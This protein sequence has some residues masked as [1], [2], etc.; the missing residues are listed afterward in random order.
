MTFENAFLL[1]AATLFLFAVADA[2][3]FARQPRDERKPRRELF[4]EIAAIA[5][6]LNFFAFIL[7]DVLL[8]GDA[9]NGK[10]DS[11]RYYLGNHGA[12]TEVTRGVFVYSACHA[13]L[14]L[15]GLIAVAAASPK[16]GRGR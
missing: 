13:T 14:A 10:V 1:F 9:L 12:Y 8:G 11:G 7:I 16:W 6:S 5:A 4:L 15:L 2:F 3:R